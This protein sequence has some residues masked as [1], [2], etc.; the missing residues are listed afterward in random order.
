[1]TSLLFG[2]IRYEGKVSATGA[3]FQVKLSVESQATNEISASLFEGDIALLSPK[4][5]EGWRIVNQGKKFTLYAAAPGK[6]EIELQLAA[7]SQRLEPWNNVAFTGPE[8]ALGSLSVEA[9]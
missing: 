8:A 6:H 3:V 2:E 7:K 1:M 9:T 5:P 4:L